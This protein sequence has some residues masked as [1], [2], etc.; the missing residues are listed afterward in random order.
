MRRRKVFERIRTPHSGVWKGR[1]SIREY[2]LFSRLFQ[3]ALSR[4]E[5]W[6]DKCHMGCVRG[7]SWIL[8]GSRAR[9]HIRGQL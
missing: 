2:E 6:Q 1:D 4:C 8:A 3:N 9:N 5:L 7:S